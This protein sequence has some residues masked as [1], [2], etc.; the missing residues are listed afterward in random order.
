MRRKAED[1]KHTFF[2]IQEAI[3]HATTMPRDTR[4]TT[5]I[6]DWSGPKDFLQKVLN[7][8][9]FPAE[10][11]AME[12]V[13]AEVFSTLQTS[14]QVERVKEYANFG[15]PRMLELSCGNIPTGFSRR[16]SRRISSDTKKV[17]IFSA[18]SFSAGVEPEE[19]RYK[20]AAS[21]A[22]REVLEARG[23]QSEIWS[24]GHM[25]SCYIPSGSW[26]GVCRIVGPGEHILTRDLA[27][28]ASPAW[29]RMLGF[30]LQ[31]TGGSPNP[32]YGFPT[33]DYAEVVKYMQE[34]GTLLEGDLVI[35]PPSGHLFD[36]M[37]SASKC[38]EWIEA[39]VARVSA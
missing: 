4:N 10:E 32:G 19:I 6:K 37:N 18:W 38:K 35:M 25:Q 17:K 14:M 22:L 2:S 5:W 16:V 7:A 36:R 24:T 12:K 15:N 39:E 29:F 31:E 21:L 23:I 8:D 33:R 26:T 34:E 30:T 1:A 20:T 13:R 9:A 3:N 28:V 27:A 11:D